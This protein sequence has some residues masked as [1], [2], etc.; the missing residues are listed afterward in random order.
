MGEQK[1]TNI[2]KYE[3]EDYQVVRNLF[4]NGIMENVTKAYIRVFSGKCLVPSLLQ[5]LFVALIFNFTNNIFWFFLVEF[6]L[7]MALILLIFYKY[8]SYCMDHLNTDMKDQ[9]LSFWTSRGEHNAG[10]FVAEIDGEVVGT[11]AY[12]RNDNMKDTIEMNRVSVA[13]HARGHGIAKM[14][15]EKVEHIAVRLNAK[16]LYAVTTCIQYAAIQLY[17]RDGWREIG[18]FGFG[19]VSQYFHGM[20]NLELEK[21]INT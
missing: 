10:Y 18:R 9:E 12:S 4:Y 6:L 2:R 20:D 1:A 11:I 7:Q 21:C 14:M 13:K 17:K 15:M 5:V 19:S 16:K 3:K 8:W